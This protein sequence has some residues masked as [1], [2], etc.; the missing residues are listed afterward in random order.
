MLLHVRRFAMRY[1]ALPRPNYLRYTTFTDHPDDQGFL[2]FI[3]WEA[4][5]YY[6]KPTVWNRWGP[7]A[8]LTWI[9]GRPLPGDEGSKYYP[10]GYSIPDVGPKN[11]LGKGQEYQGKIMDGLKT[12]RAGQCPFH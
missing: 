10:E 1:L 9:M 11:F 7:T 2:S 12:S 5:P 3:R 8:W 6:V 4:A